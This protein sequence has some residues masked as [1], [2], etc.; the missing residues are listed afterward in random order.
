V[1]ATVSLITLD[2][3]LILDSLLSSFRIVRGDSLAMASLPQSF[4]RVGGRGSI[5]VLMAVK[6]NSLFVEVICKH[7]L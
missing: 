5:L 4:T 2:K 1:R 3:T 6:R 7:C